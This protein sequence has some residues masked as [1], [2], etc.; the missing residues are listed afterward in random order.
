MELP[1]YTVTEIIVNITSAEC[2]LKF[3]TYTD[4]KIIV[5]IT[6]AMDIWMRYEIAYI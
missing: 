4:T 1:I 3:P 5:N 2:A 6:N